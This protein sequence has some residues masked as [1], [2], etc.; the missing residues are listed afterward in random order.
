MALNSTACVT[1]ISSGQDLSSYVHKKQQRGGGGDKSPPAARPPPAHHRP[2]TRGLY[3]DASTR[4]HYL[5]ITGGIYM[6]NH[7]A[8]Y[9]L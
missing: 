9:Y 7:A 3:Q 2:D 8:I 5:A 6:R 1:F 4:K